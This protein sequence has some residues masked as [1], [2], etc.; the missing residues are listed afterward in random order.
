MKRL[1]LFFAVNLLVV[2]A[3]SIVINLLGLK[4]YISSRG[5]DHRSLLVFCAVWGFAGSFISLQIS[6]WSAKMAMGVEV[7]DPQNPP[8][9]EAR[10]IVERVS[11]LCRHAGLETL[12]EIGVYESPEVNAFAPRRSRSLL[13]LSSGLLQRMDD[14]AVEG[15]IGHEIAHI[16][17]G[18]MVTMTLIQGVVNTFVMFF[19]RAATF[20]LDNMLRSRDDDRGGGLGPFA[21]MMVVMVLETV[22]MLLASPII[23]WFSRQREFRA[24]AGGAQFAGRDTMIH[25]LESLK[26]NTQRVDNSQAS[27]ATLKIN[28]HA[29]GLLARLYSSH[30]PLDARIEALKR[31]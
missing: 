17:N 16:A 8:T 15:V 18:D 22:F 31:A 21:H 23:Y 25:A 6:R 12:P 3:I 4:P 30:P 24:D 7:I 27:L 14:E 19:A 2:L 5:L 29:P 10:R 26:L 1:F 28:G 11:A 13:A 20:A 9:P